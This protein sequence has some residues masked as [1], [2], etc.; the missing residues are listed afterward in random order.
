MKELKDSWEASA[1]AKRSQVYIN[2]PIDPE[3]CSVAAAQSFRG[4]DSEFRARDKLQKEQMRRW[5]QEKIAEK[6]HLTDNERKA[7]LTYANFVS[8][9]D[10]ILRA[11]HEEESAMRRKI[12]RETANANREV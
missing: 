11:S 4:E 1:E 5:I 8:T 9:M 2:D 6:A 7:D 10:D 12:L 3:S